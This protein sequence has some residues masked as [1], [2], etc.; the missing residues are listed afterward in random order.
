MAEKPVRFPTKQ[1]RN[2]WQTVGLGL[3]HSII[4]LSKEEKNTGGGGLPSEMQAGYFVNETGYGYGK[5][6][7]TFI[8]SLAI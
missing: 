4:A 6:K 7:P 2:Q 5:G 8:E 1:R 3:G